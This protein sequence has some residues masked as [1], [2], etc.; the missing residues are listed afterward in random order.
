MIAN[1]RCLI[2]L[3]C[4][5]NP[6]PKRKTQLITEVKW[7]TQALVNP[8]AALNSPK[9]RE[10]LRYEI[11]PYINSYYPERVYY[12]ARYGNETYHHIDKAIVKL[13]LYKQI[14][15]Q[16]FKEEKECINRRAIDAFYK[17]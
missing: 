2:G 10:V 1:H 3:T 16:P 4:L 8:V 14:M 12:K 9:I 11:T 17:K 7:G 5:S 13:W 6:S 15:N